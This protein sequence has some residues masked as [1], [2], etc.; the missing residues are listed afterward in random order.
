[1]IAEEAP[2]KVSA[3]YS[4]FADVFSLDLASKL[5]KHTRINNHAIELVNG[6]Q[7]PYGPIYSLGPIE[8]ETLKTYIE[9][10]LVNGFIRPVKSPAGASILFDQKSDNSFWLYVNYQGL[11]NL[12]IK[13]QYP[14]PLIGE[15]L[16]R[17]GRAKQF[18]QL[19]LTSAYH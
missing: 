5:P 17:L 6:Q 11:H 3:K 14:L 10:N 12:T 9:T 4:D 19:E 18:T 2:T 1:M 8:S 7:L 15:S 13:N 16:D